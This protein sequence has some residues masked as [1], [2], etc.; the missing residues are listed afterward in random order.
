MPEHRS[1]RTSA[2]WQEAAAM[3][4]NPR[5]LA[6][7]ALFLALCIAI[8]SVFIPLPNN[9]RIYFTFVPKALCAAICG[10]IAALVFGFADDLL[11]FMIH[12]SGAFF[13][14]YTLSAMLGMLYYALGLYRAKITV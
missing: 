8:S 7:A 2:Y 6:V 5:V 1:L 9:L 12:P 4:H 10:P 3:L 14:G 11:G 13:F